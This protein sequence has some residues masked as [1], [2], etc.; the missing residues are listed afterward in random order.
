MAIT[1]L[2]HLPLILLFSGIPVSV[3]A[4]WVRL[5][6]LASFSSILAFAVHFW[7]FINSSFLFATEW[8][9]ILWHYHNWFT[10][11][12]TEAH[13]GMDKTAMKTMDVVFLFLLDKY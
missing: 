4:Q 5:S 10:H 3:A 12:P 8:Y 2:V 9:V 6:Y 7:C 1:S 13:V 11:L